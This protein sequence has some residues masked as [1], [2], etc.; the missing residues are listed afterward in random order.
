M[1]KTRL[2]TSEQRWYSHWASTKRGHMTDAFRIRSSA[3]I[4]VLTMFNS[5]YYTLNSP[6]SIFDAIF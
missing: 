5:P 3:S 4:V 6:F 1:A 2:T